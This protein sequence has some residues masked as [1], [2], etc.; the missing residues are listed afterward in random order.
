[1]KI[2]FIGDP[3]GNLEK[4]KEIP[5]DNS[6]DLIVL[7]GDLGKSNL[8]RNIAFQ[9]YSNQKTQI[10]N[11]KYKEAFF[12]TFNSTMEIITYLKQFAPIKTIYGNVEFSKEETLEISKK[13]NLELPILD[14][15]LKKLNVD[16]INNQIRIVNDTKIG[17]LQYFIDTNWVNEFDPNNIDK[18]NFA[19]KETTYSNKILEEFG[20]IDVL[21]CHQPPYQ[22]LDRVDSQNAPENWRGKHAGSK[23]I[24]NYIQKYQPKYIFCG[25]IHE[26]EGFEKVENTEVYNLGVGGYKIIEL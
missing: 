14:D 21:V 22:I 20:F 9:K 7:T 24:L 17:G 26:G 13:I 4:I 1:M 3:H 18:M 11:S 16:V 6:I 5:L 10:S 8:I 19:Q 23:T 15:E 25:H 12:E 2:C